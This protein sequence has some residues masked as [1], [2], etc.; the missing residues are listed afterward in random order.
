MSNL[1]RQEGSFFAHTVLPQPALTRFTLPKNGKRASLLAG[2][3]HRRGK[4]RELNYYHKYYISNLS[5]RTV[6]QITLGKQ[7]PDNYSAGLLYNL[8]FNQQR[9]ELK[10]V[11][12]T[13]RFWQ[14]GIEL[15]TV[16]K[17]TINAAQVFNYN[18]TAFTQ[19]SGMPP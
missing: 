8:N 3:S 5:C 10:R 7:G 11:A 9:A 12:A 4:W 14:V 19:Y 15:L 1:G 17:R 16:N 18:F 6:T 2:P 13:Q